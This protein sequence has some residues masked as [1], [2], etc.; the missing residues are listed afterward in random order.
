MVRDA[1]VHKNFDH[2]ADGTVRIGELPPGL[3]VTG[4]MAWY[5]YRG[6]YSGIGHAFG[7]Y[8]RKAIALRVEPVGAPG[9]VYICEPDDHKSD[10]QA[11]LLTL[12]WTPVK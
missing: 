7:E 9:D 12:F 2:Y 11:K 10:G 1:D 5:V 8:M 3:H 6:P 4:K